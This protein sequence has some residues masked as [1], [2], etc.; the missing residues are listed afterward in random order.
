MAFGLGLCISSRGLPGI[1]VESPITPVTDGMALSATWRIAD[2]SQTTLANAEEASFKIVARVEPSDTGIL[3]EQGGSGRGIIIYVF[4]AVLYA[5][6]G[7]GSGTGTSSSRAFVQY[8]L[9]KR[10]EL[11]EAS[12]SITNN[13]CALYVDGDL[14]GTDTLETSTLAGSDIGGLGRVYSLA[15]ANFGGW[16]TDGSGAFT[17]DINRAEIFLNQLTTDVA[18]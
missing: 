17:G 15:A 7:D 12:C 8:T 16:T 13:L 5:Q 4:G 6:F 11:I 18:V 9:T 14:V 3:F 2:G 1:A 10:I